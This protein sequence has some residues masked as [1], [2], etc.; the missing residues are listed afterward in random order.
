MEEG[1]WEV[2]I[3]Q[4]CKWY[5]FSPYIPLAKFSAIAI[6]N[7]KGDREMQS[8]CEPREKKKQICGEELAIPKVLSQLPG[9][10]ISY[11]KLFLISP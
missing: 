6:L 10:H 4:A 8:S 2:F 7:S 1:I 11:L 3:D 9:T 5:P